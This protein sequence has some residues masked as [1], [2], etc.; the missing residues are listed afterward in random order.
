MYFVVT[1]ITCCVDWKS[2]Q[3]VTQRVDVA[4]TVVRVRALA[5]PSMFPAPL[6]QAMAA[7]PFTVACVVAVPDALP[8]SASPPDLGDTLVLINGQVMGTIPNETP[9][10]VAA[11]FGILRV[12]LS[13]WLGQGNPKGVDAWTSQTHDDDPFEVLGVSPADPFDKVRAAWRQRL[14]EYH[15][16]KYA[17]AGA[18]IRAVAIDESQRL[19]AAFARIAAQRGARTLPKV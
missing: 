15:P 1:G 8:V 18:K 7:L 13:P 10:V 14:A 9:D 11:V 12:C 2:L 19:N 4:A 3:R 17:Q 16:D 6:S 5:V